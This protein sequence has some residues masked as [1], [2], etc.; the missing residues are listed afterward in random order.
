MRVEY[1]SAA[2]RRASVVALDDRELKDL[3]LSKSEFG[4]ERYGWIVC[5]G[6]QEGRGALCDDVAHD[7][8]HKDAGISAAAHVWVRAHG[9][10]FNEAGD[11]HAL[12]SHGKESIAFEDAV[13][14]AELDG[15]LAERAGLGEG[16]KLD[17]CRDIG[18]VEFAE[19]GARL[20]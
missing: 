4:V 12:P 15:A 5:Q 3:S 6:V 9:A 11:A 2:V 18:R 17:H 14:I 20:Q 16:G 8:A 1:L 19:G 10:D 7:P 13:E